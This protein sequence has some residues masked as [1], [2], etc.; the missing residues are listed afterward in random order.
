MSCDPYLSMQQP[1]AQS[2][3]ECA[4][5]GRIKV[6]FV[7]NCDL[8]RGFGRSPAIVKNCKDIS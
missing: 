5:Y 7:A 2:R 6:Y 1:D 3:A 8:L 4:I